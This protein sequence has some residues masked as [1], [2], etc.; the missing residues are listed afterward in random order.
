[1]PFFVLLNV[2]TVPPKFQLAARLLKVVDPYGIYKGGA[3]NSANLSQLSRFP[4]LFASK[5]QANLGQQA[6]FTSKIIDVL[7]GH[8]EHLAVPQVPWDVGEV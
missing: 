7:H 6:E 2:C 5:S 8:H 1:M 4:K 3:R